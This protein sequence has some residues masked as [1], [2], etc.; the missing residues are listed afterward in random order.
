VIRAVKTDLRGGIHVRLRSHSPDG[1][2]QEV[3]SLLCVYQALSRLITYAA[4]HQL[5][6]DRISFTRARNIAR[7]SVNWTGGSFSP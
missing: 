6:P 1:V 5:D 3:W 4:A 7:R 2:R